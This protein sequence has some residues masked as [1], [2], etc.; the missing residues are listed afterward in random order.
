[1]QRMG[2]TIAAYTDALERVIGA[3][4]GSLQLIDAETLREWVILR[5]R[6]FK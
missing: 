6:S 1:M 4:A 5:Q 2:G 3:P